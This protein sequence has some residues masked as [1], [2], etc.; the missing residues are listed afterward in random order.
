M[1]K[2]SKWRDP[3]TG[4]QPFLPPVAPRNI[5]PV[6]LALLGPLN[7]A[8]SLLR[9]LLLAVVALVHAVVVDWLCLL[10]VPIPPL[11]RAINGALTSFTTRLALALMGYWWITTELVSH[12]R[13]K[14]GVSQISKRSPRAGDLIIANW[15]GY[16][17][18][19]YLAFRHSPTFLLPVFSSHNEHNA[20]K[21]GR[22][23]GTGSANISTTLAQP[24]FLGYLPV[25]LLSLIARTG[26]L[27]DTYDIPPKGM[28][29]TLRDARRKE[30]RPVVVFPEGTTGNGRALLKFGEGTLAEGDVGGDDQGIVW[31]KF[32]RHSP[33]TGFAASA[34]CPLP[35]PL[36]HLFFSQLYTPTAFAYRDLHVR[37]LHPAASP[38]SP[39]FLP[40]EI[41]NNAPGGLDAAGKDHKAVWREACA[42]VLA[43][44][45]RVRRVKGMGWVEKRAFLNYWV[46]SGRR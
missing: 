41:L 35:T 22:H 19:L 39:S 28:Y 45:G 3:A 14:T 18:V 46:R 42:T 20:P 40:S 43:E 44:T 26:S 36:K 25:P 16:V 27:P 4:I 17:D 38:S 7:V 34:T 31:I 29:K 9:S 2:F 33:P 30:K 21:T 8:H 1:E 15:T 5:S 23:T 37:T 10:F 6:F 13:G 11:Y 12:K 32:L 24:P